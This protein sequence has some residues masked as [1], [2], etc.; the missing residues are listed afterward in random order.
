MKNII[1]F[2]CFT[3]ILHAQDF[4][5]P[6]LDSLLDILGENNRFM[7]GLSIMHDGKEVYQKSIGFADVSRKSEAD[8]KTKYRI[9][10]ITKTY[11]ATLL[12]QFVE[13]GKLNLTDTLSSYFPEVANAEKITIDDMLHHR[14][15]IFNI[16][17]AVDFGTWVAEPRSREEILELL[18]MNEAAFEPKEKAGYSNT[19]YI[20]LSY[21]LEDIAKKPF[22]Q[23]LKDRI[24]TPLGLKR[25]EFGHKIQPEKNEAIP[26]YRKNGTWNPVEPLTDM[27]NPMGAGSVVSTPT[28]VTQFYNALFSGKL[29]SKNSFHK[30]TDVSTGTGYGLGSG[31]FNGREGFGH[32]G[33]IDGFQ[34]FTFFMPQEKVAMA[35]SSNAYDIPFFY[36]LESVVSIYFDDPYEIPQFKPLQPFIKLN[37][38]EL[39]PFLGIY[40]DPDFPLKIKVFKEENKLMAQATDQDAFQVDAIEKNI[41]KSFEEMITLD[42][43][44]QE[45]KMQF[46]QLGQPTVILTREN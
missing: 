31:A 4:N 1:L 24:I 7:G 5:K 2:L 29:V 18:K 28:E 45:N 25:T 32:N 33:S 12:M 6:K 39:E 46:E 19:N 35:L 14:S 17:E 41:F 9:G 38:E 36:V 27:Q 16:T 30:M 42:F 13:E 37:S 10:S 23:L 43:N 3:A 11:T 34:A 8:R 15:G 26:Y 40:S 44:V 21:I 22:S 20:L